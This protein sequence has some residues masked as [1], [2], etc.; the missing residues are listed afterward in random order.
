[1]KKSRKK[2]LSQRELFSEGDIPPVES[3]NSYGSKG[4]IW[5]SAFIAYMEAMVSHPVYEGMPDAIKE[6]G[7]IQWEAPSNR[8]GGQYQHTHHK[9][10]EWWR[11]KA[12]SMDI[13][14]TKDKW[15]SRA[16]KMIH[17]TGEKPCKRCGRIMRIAYVYPNEWLVQKFRK[18]YGEDFEISILEPITD[19]VQRA[20]DLMGGRIIDEISDILSTKDI[21]VPGFGDDLESFLEWIEET[22]IPM[23]PG[24]LSPG[25]MSNAPD[26]LDGFH[27]FNRCCRG[28]A[29]KGRNSENLLSYVTDRRVF[30]YWSAGDWIAADRLMG[31]IRTTLKNEPC[32]DGGNGPATA[33]HIGPISL[34]F[35]HRPEFRLLS[36]AANSAKNNRMSLQD[37]QHLRR[38]EEAGTQVVSWYAGYLWD[39]RKNEIDSEEMALRFS[40]QL[41]DNQRNAMR[42]LCEIYDSGKFSFLLYLLELGYA[43]QNVEFINL[44]AKDFVTCYEKIVV[45]KRHTKYA[46]EQ[47]ARRVRIGFEALRAYKEKE[48][49]HFLAIAKETV[50]GYVQQAISCLDRQ[51]KNFFELDLLLHNTLLP[52]EGNVAEEKLRMIV[53]QFPT[54]TVEVFEEAKALLSKAMAVI[55]K[56]IYDASGSDRYVRD[57]FEF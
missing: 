24:L 7:K 51:D 53:N 12:E 11:R 46:T 44:S 36:K 6:D 31:L 37:V 2:K 19:V 49:R 18:K 27:S 28:S 54:H 47:K 14:V 52:E 3:S 15:I 40:K 30:E 32:A 10:R 9:R 26:R 13:D 8:S 39:R 50:D 45:E 4:E 56:A 43:D 22:Y 23:E 48:N 34:G 29:D 57:Q 35:C 5:T 33:D 25:A 41:R 20:Y 16:A 55:G 42:T 1:M 17:P 38:C 21:R